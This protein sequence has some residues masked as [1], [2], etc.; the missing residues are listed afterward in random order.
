[1]EKPEQEQPAVPGQGRC[2]GKKPCCCC[3]PKASTKKLPSL[4]EKLD[5]FF[6]PEDFIIS[7]VV[8]VISMF[9]ETENPI[10]P[11]AKNV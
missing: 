8:F 10:Q 5:L 2:V 7:F 1:M 3:W 4:S 6:A 11:R 9:N